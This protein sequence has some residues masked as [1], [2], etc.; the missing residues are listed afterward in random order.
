MTNQK[1]FSTGDRVKGS[2]YGKEYVGTV[3]NA[4]AHTMNLS[5]KH[6]IVLD[7][8]ISIFGAERDRIIVSIWE[9]SNDDGN[10]I[11]AF[12]N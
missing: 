1:P 6:Y 10:T 3:E 11:E 12:L 2:Y 5:Y 7:N 8:P 4:R 9:P